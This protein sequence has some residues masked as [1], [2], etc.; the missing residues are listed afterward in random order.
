MHLS[1]AGFAPNERVDVLWGCASD[2]CDGATSVASG[3]TDATGVLSADVLPP[4][5]A[6][7]GMTTIAAIGASSG[8]V[9]TAS[10]TL[11]TG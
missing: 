6:A 7:A 1:V 8:T 3:V 9:A 11:V 2:G 4:A 10:Y 5:R